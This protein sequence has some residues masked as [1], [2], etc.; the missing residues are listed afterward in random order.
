MNTK[1]VKQL[2]ASCFTY[3]WRRFASPAGTWEQNFW[4]YFQFFPRDF[5][6][7]KRVLEAGSGMGRHTYYLAQMAR[8]VVTIDLGDAIRVTAE[9][10]TGRENVHLV[11]ADIDYLPFKPGSFDFVCSIGVLHHLPEPAVGF[12][13]LVQSLRPGGFVHVYLYWALEDAPTWK[14][15]L[16][17]LATL[18]RRLT[19]GLPY[20][21]L[22]KVA[23]CVAASAYLIFSVPYRYLSHWS[24]T[25]SLVKNF[26]FQRYADD[27]FKVCYNDQ[28]DRLSAP[29][30]HR[31]TRNQVVELFTRSGLTDVRTMP[32]YG[33]LAC[34]RK[35]AVVT[36]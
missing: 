16:L 27:G 23:W 7:G 35:P 31:F 17:A 15:S 8:K 26:P 4:G 12:Y 33:W 25:A 18:T 3:E 21:V 1:D 32:H 34:G 2:T 5:F 19:V 13:N 9:T 14:R 24:A 10:V 29:L 22:E 20:P 28:F 30:E 6:K 36:E 11:K